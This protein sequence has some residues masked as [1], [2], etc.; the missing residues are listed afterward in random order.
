MRVL[1]LSRI[2]RES[3]YVD[4]WVE[5]EGLRAALAAADFVFLALPRTPDTRHIVDAAALETMKPTAYLINVGRGTAV[6]EAALVAA[7]GAGRI[8]GAGLEVFETEPLPPESPSRGLLNVLITPHVA[9]QSAAVAD[10][11]ARFLAE[12]PPVRGGRAAPGHRGQARRL[13]HQ[14]RG[15]TRTSAISAARGSRRGLGL[16]GRGT[17]PR[18]RRGMGV[19]TPESDEDRRRRRRCDGRACSVHPR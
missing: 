18:R 5:R 4:E 13:L 1:G 11:W 3:P 15:E 19:G 14:S 7:L 17:G 10:D 9:N 2:R 6:D 8:A 12:Y 16:G